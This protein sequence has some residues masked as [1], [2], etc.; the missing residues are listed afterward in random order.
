MK[1]FTLSALLGIFLLPALSCA[2]ATPT[3]CIVA[4]DGTGDFTTI[5]GAVDSVPDSNAAPFTISIKTGKYPGHVIV[6]KTKP[7]LIFAGEN[8]ENTILSWD[9]NVNEPIP[10]GARQVQS[11]VCGCEPTISGRP[12]LPSKTHRAIT[13][14]RW[15]CAWTA[16]A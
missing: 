8:K 11:R 15:R 9:R 2:A 3:S 14:R 4:T 1:N 7:R 6:P 16:T 13:V 12:T 5:Q 10:P